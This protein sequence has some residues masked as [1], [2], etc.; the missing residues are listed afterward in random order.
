MHH[1][2]L[3]NLRFDTVAIHAGQGPDPTFGALATPIYQTSTFC[4]DTVEEGS[5]KFAKLRPGFVYSRAGNPTCRALEEKIAQL[6]GGEDCLVTGSGMGAVGSVVVSL[7]RQG[8]HVVCG[9]VVYG[10]TS[11]V[12]RTNLPNFGVETSFVDT[13]DVS[14]VEAAL[15]PNTKMVYLETPTNPMM[16]VTDIAAL[17]ALCKSREILLVVDN[18]FAPPPVQFPLKLGADLVLH[19]LTKYLN[20]HGDVLGGA[21]VG[22]KQMVAQIRSVG[23]TKICGTVLSP[24]NAYLCL[25]GMKTL[26]LRVRRHCESALALARYLETKPCVKQVFYP[27]LESSPY[28]ALA[29]RQMNGLYSGILSFELAEGAGGKSS[30]ELGKAVVNALQIFAIAVSLGDPDSLV[31]HPAS[32]THASV[33]KADREASGITDGLIRLSVGLEDPADLIADF[34]QAFAAAGL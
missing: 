30:F 32:M 31:Q 3:E 27:G 19:S 11:V 12:M 2:D 16:A 6:E 7:L 22:S 23:A 25:R 34:E 8:D 28:H 13:S 18:T 9:D 21:V 29:Q 14:L 15:R 26:G 1:L 33:P 24:F 17:S 20:G 10:G 5:E 4:F